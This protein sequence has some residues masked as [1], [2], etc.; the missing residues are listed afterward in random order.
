MDGY[1]LYIRNKYGSLLPKKPQYLPHKH[2]HIYYW[3][4]QHIVQPEDTSL[5]IYDKVIKIVQCIVGAL[6]YVGRAVNNKLLV[7]LMAIGSQK[8]ET[9]EETENAIKKLLDFVATYPDN[10][11]LFRKSYM[12]LAAHADTW[13]LNKSRP[14][15][16]SGDHIFLL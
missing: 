10:G 15:S 4:K 16:I 12:I 14:R 13:F 6:L 11:I 2:H 9:T 1:I 8:A 3:S 7:S 5:P